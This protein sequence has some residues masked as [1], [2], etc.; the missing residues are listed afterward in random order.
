MITVNQRLQA[1]DCH[2]F[3]LTQPFFFF[4]GV[5]EGTPKGEVQMDE[6]MPYF[7][8]AGDAGS[9]RQRHHRRPCVPQPVLEETENR[10]FQQTRVWLNQFTKL[11]YRTTIQQHPFASLRRGTKVDQGA[12]SCSQLPGNAQAKPLVVSL[13]HF[14]FSG[15]GFLIKIH[16]VTVK[17]T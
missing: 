17:S 10:I 12:G 7:S 14:N 2:S 6:L 11:T 3:P 8:N 4:K 9:A 5:E 1:E 13:C 15:R 16:K